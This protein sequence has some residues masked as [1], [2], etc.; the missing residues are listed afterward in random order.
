MDPETKLAELG[1][2]LPE[3]Y[4]PVA[5]YVPTMRAGDLLFVSGQGPLG[6]DG[7]FPNGKV[8]V[9]V[10]LEEAQAAARVCCLNGLAAVKVEMGDLALVKRAVKLTCFVAS[11]PGFNQQSQVANGA[12]ELLQEIFGEPGRHARAAVGVAELPMGICVEVDFI[13]EV[14]PTSG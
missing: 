4:K 3:P 13:F 14:A 2:E 8:P 11:S 5:S 9:D 10:S 1:Y 7:S 6:P 12:S